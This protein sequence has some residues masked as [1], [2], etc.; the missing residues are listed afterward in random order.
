MSNQ[1]TENTY[2]FWGAPPESQSVSTMGIFVF[3]ECNESAIEQSSFEALGKARELAEALGTG[4]AAIL[5]NWNDKNLARSLI[6]SGA[7][8]VFMSSDDRFQ[9]YKTELY[10][11]Q[12]LS[13][14]Q[15]ENS[16]IFIAALSSITRDFFPR[17]AQRIPTGLVSG[18]TNLEIDTTERSLLATH[19]IYGGKMFEVMTWKKSRPQ[20]VLLQPGIFPPPIMDEFRS[21]AIEKL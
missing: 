4:V 17:L 19:P 9:N 21:G 18:C 14:I 20:M 16:E 8:K 10:C 7:N 6:Q 15:R 5:L 11:N 3:V 12:L 13:L 2:D 1:E